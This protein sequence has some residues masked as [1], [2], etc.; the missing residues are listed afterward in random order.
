MKNLSQIF[1]CFGFCWGIALADSNIPK[2]SNILQK[3]DQEEYKEE[4][5]ELKE[6]VSKALESKKK[7]SYEKLIEKEKE[8]Q[9]SRESVPVTEVKYLIKT[10]VPKTAKYLPFLQTLLNIQPGT[11]PNP[12]GVSLIGSYTHER[13]RVVEFNGKMGDIGGKFKSELGGLCSSLGPIA[14]RLCQSTISGIGDGINTAVGAGK[15]KK[16]DLSEG[17]VDVKTTAVGVKADMYL[18]P[19]MNIFVT[20]AYLSVEQSTNVGTATITTEPTKI[21]GQNIGSF[22]LPF[23]VGTISN[24]LDGFLVMAGTNLA[25]GYKGFFLSCMISGGY[26][27]LDDL[28]NNIKGFV[29]KPYM[30]IAPRIGYTYNGIFTVHTGVQRIQLFGETKGSD[31]SQITGGLVAGYT[32]K[33]DK[34]PVTFLAGAQFMFMRDL[35]LAIEYV[36]SPDTNG[37]NAELVY[38][39]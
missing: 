24:K 33:I 23:N 20:T 15:S 34:F 17:I 7:T 22:S 29:E 31:L 27:R 28:K 38:R 12:I 26:V 1:L 4:G 21:L 25:I 30:Y 5:G 19:F 18:F 2:Q 35:G 13:Y 8:L 6:E 32:T 3:T 11:L 9:V 36:G 10:P 16:W 39:F 14:G 37:I